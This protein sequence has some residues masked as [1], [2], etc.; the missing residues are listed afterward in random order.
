MG[1]IKK[2][3]G[4]VLR[5]LD[6]GESDKIVSVLSRESGKISLLAKGARKTESR[7]GAALELLTLSEFI[8]YHRAGLKTLREADIVEAY[9]ALKGEYERLESALRCARWVNHLLEDDH[10]EE[11][12]YRLFGDLLEALTEESDAASAR[13][14]ELG[15]KLKLLSSQGLAPTLDR[16][17]VCERILRQAWFSFEKGGVLCERCQGGAHAFPLDVGIARGLHMALHLPFEKL[18]RL[19]LSAET[20]ARGE[21]LIDEFTAHHLRPAAIGARRSLRRG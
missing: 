6:F 11:R 9:S 19:K 21:Q 13:L 14:Y 16:C 5:A 7:F 17:A 4:F 10:I 1:R 3:T 18:K 8:Y 20:A 12:V 2:A 15:F